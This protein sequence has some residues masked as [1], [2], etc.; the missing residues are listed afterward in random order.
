MSVHRLGA[1]AIVFCT[2]GESHESAGEGR[3]GMDRGLKQA[4][5]F[6]KVFL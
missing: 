6:F 1:H 2:S 3:D 5:H 4:L